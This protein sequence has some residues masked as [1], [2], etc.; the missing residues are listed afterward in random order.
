[1][2]LLLERR[3]NKDTWEGWR[4]SFDNSET[5]IAGKNPKLPVVLFFPEKKLG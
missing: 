4:D 5:Y 2:K 1:M 3:I